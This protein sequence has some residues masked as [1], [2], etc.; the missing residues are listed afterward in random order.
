MHLSHA[1]REITFVFTAHNFFIAL[2]A[3]LN[4]HPGFLAP[5]SPQLSSSAYLHRLS[6]EGNKG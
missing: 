6:K 3:A 2:V 4:L 1:R 5:F